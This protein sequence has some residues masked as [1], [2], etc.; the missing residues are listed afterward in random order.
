[1][2]DQPGDA[3]GQ[4]ADEGPKVIQVSQQM[5]QYARELRRLRDT[6][7]EVGRCYTTLPPEEAK[8][9]PALAWETVMRGEGAASGQKVTIKLPECQIV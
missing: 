7:D 2:S 5:D 3:I 9:A 6:I 4:L 8:Q 1:M